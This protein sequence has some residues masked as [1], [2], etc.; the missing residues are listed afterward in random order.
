MYKAIGGIEMKLITQIACKKCYKRK[1]YL[2]NHQERCKHE[3]IEITN[4]V[5][6]ESK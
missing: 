1:D 3:W 5:W 2:D 6:E 4:T